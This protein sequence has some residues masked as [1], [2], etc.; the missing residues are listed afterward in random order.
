MFQLCVVSERNKTL[1][2][3]A[4]AGRRSHVLRDHVVTEVA[5]SRASGEVGHE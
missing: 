4:L 2:H 1:L 5:D 3:D